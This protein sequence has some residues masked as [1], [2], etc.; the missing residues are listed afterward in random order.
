MNLKF[1]Q[2]KP[3]K[4]APAKEASDYKVKSYAK[5]GGF[6]RS[7]DRAGKNQNSSTYGG[8]GERELQLRMELLVDQ[9]LS[10]QR[11]VFKPAQELVNFSLTDQERFLESDRKSVV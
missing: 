9:V 10:S 4:K 6:I 5:D 11:S 3:K 2:K 1:W 8:M 7:P